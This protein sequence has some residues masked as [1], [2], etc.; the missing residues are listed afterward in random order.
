MLSIEIWWR[1]LR[2]TMISVSTPS[3]IPSIDRKA[4]GFFKD[5]LNSLPMQQFV[6]LCP[7]CYTFLCTGK[8]SNNMLQYTNQAEKKTA[9]GV[10]RKVKYAHL[11]LEHYLDAL[12]NFHTYLSTE[13]GQVYPAYFAHSSHVQGRLDS[14]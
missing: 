4:I 11:H 7:K 14:I 1:M 8:V 12:R 5:E 2:F 10:K 6:G 3:T 9:K 13:P